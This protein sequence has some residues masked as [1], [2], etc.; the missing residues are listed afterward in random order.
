MDETVNDF[1]KEINEIAPATNKKQVSCGRFPI[2]IH[3]FN[4]NNKIL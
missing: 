3:I 1:L 2:H 4:F